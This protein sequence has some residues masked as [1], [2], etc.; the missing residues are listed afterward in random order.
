MKKRTVRIIT[1]TTSV[2]RKIKAHLDPAAEEVV[3]LSGPAGTVD[4]VLVSRTINA[5]YCVGP[6]VVQPADV[7]LS[8]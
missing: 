4:V 7:Q 6:T 3:G 5:V 8:E 1:K 2:E